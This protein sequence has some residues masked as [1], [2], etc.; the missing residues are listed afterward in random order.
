MNLVAGSG[1][2]GKRGV[3]LAA[4]S[5]LLAAAS[6]PGPAKGQRAVFV[7]LPLP[8]AHPVAVSGWRRFVEVAERDKRFVFR[9]FVDGSLLGRERA[10]AGLAHGDAQMGYATLAADPAGLPHRVTLGRLA[11]AG[12]DPLAGAAAMSEFVML[13]CPACL[14]SLAER[15]IVFLGSHA[16]GPFHLLSARPL[17]GADTLKGARI[18]SPGPPWDELIRHLRGQPET[19]KGSL[20]RALEKGEIEAVLGPTALLSGPA[21]ARRVQA[22]TAVHLG[23]Y[24][25]ASPFTA[26]LGFWRT[27]TPGDRAT[28]LDAAPAGLAAAA[29]AYR[30]A[31]EE[32]RRA[33]E[34]A[35]IAIGRAHPEPMQAA[36]RFNPEAG[37]VEL[38]SEGEGADALAAGFRGLYE[39]YSS[40]FAEEDLTVGS[41]AGILRREIF[42]LL[43]S[44]TYGLE[45]QGR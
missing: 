26:S 28:L 15:G 6:L 8:A 10:V 5:L 34:E 4:G 41:V 31:D 38:R 39:K 9:L 20:A 23:I 16:A 3:A 14:K 24:H 11:L 44:A 36:L 13:H 45:S 18:A 1:L 33:M 40:L 29:L 35:G 43:G 7:N 2:Q 32:A 25:V 21:L 37:T 22:V 19:V 12:F 42:D 27:L 17:A 30:A